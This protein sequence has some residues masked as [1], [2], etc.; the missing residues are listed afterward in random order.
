MKKIK[1]KP[2][3]TILSLLLFM[4]LC[5]SLTYWT[6]QWMKP[7][8]RPVAAPLVVQQAIDPAAAA[9]LFGGDLQPVAIASNYQLLGVV[10]AKNG[11]GSAAIVSVDG[12]PAQALR[13]GSD[14]QP[15]VQI[16]EVHPDYI[17]LSNGGVNQRVVLPQKSNNAPA[18]PMTMQ[19]SVP[20]PPGMPPPQPEADTRG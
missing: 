1:V 11:T 3:N 6:L 5:A 16:S 17:L 7:K 19:P 9:N 13:V 14:I 4:A 8:Q 2:A 20:P 18:A 10:A 12:K 15:G